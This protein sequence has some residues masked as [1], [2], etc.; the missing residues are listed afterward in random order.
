[1]GIEHGGIQYKGALW[2][3]KQ[4]EKNER[5]PDNECSVSVFMAE[6]VDVFNYF[7]FFLD[8]VGGSKCGCLLRLSVSSNSTL[9][10]VL[11]SSFLSTLLLNHKVK[12]K[13]VL[14]LI[15]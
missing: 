1:V 6:D 7:N 15:S 4:V 5:K 9:C 11:V 3:G 10:M 2:L 12:G 8:D 13:V 14:G